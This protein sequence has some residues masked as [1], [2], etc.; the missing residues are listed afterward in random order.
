MG[1]RRSIFVIHKWHI[2]LRFRKS[3]GSIVN[4]CA[5]RD[6][7]A[8]LTQPPHRWWLYL[9]KY[10]QHQKSTN[11]LI[12]A[13][14]TR[15]MICAQIRGFTIVNISSAP[16]TDHGVRIAKGARCRA[17][18]SCALCGSSRRC[19]ATARAENRRFQP[20]S[21]LCAH[22][23]APYK[24]DFHGETLRVLNRP[25][26]ARTVGG[27]CGSSPTPP[28]P[29]RPLPPMAPIWRMLV[30]RSYMV[31]ILIWFADSASAACGS[32][33]RVCH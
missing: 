10:V 24:M 11:V 4:G 2:I 21:A 30:Y 33:G 20:L 13:N 22:T 8:L 5:P 14:L 32:P 1:Q 28:K 9:K 23:K 3:Y 19:C 7:R 25:K 18:S 27:M 6:L 26:A 15:G 12:C 16:R 17:R 31:T 29:R